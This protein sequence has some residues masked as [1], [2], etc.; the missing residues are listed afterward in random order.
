MPRLTMILHAV[1]ATM[2]MGVGV[3][4]L[5]VAGMGTPMAITLAAAFGFVIAVPLSWLVERRISGAG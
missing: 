4:A 1:I 3:T 5:L 2:L